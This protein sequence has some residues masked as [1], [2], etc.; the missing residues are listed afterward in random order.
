MGET[1]R[2]FPRALNWLLRGEFQ[3][4]TAETA[5]SGT[6]NTRA[7]DLYDKADCQI[8]S[9]TNE[10]GQRSPRK[11]ILIPMPKVPNQANLFLTVAEMRDFQ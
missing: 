10:S 8:A 4:D 1:I 6:W 3:R 7:D 2:D 11:R 5:P 9:R